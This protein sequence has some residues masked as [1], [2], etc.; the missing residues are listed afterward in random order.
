M[1]RPPWRGRSRRP[2]NPLKRKDLRGSIPAT[3]R[4]RPLASAW[5]WFAPCGTCREIFWCAAWETLIRGSRAKE[6]IADGPPAINLSGALT[7]QRLASSWTRARASGNFASNIAAECASRPH[8]LYFHFVQVTKFS[9]P[10][11]GAGAAAHALHNARRCPAGEAGG[12]RGGVERT[13]S[14]SV[15]HRA[16]GNRSSD[17]TRKRLRFHDVDSAG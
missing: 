7:P 1:R 4:V 16:R 15:Q 11:P 9:L 3:R 5:R 17:H 13:R 14:H 2:A 8:V 12:V 10:L 6:V